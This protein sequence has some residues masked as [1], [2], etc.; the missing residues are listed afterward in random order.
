DGR[1]DSASEG[2]GGESGAESRFGAQPAEQLQAESLAR[3]LVIGA[4]GEIRSDLSR[5]KTV[6]VKDPQGED[7]ALVLGAVQIASDELDDLLEQLSA[8]DRWARVR[9]GG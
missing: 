9:F 7:G 6:S 3:L 2:G 8:V 4:D 1:I 5:R